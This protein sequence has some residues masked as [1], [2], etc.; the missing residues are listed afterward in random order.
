MRSFRSGVLCLTGE[1]GG[2]IVDSMLSLA[3]ALVWSC[4]LPPSPPLQD[5]TSEDFASRGQK[6]A[7]RGSAVDANN[8]MGQ[9]HRALLLMRAGR[10]AEAARVLS[11]LRQLSERNPQAVVDAYLNGGS[12]HEVRHS[13]AN[14][15][16]VALPSLAEEL[17]LAGALTQNQAGDLAQVVLQQAAGSFP[18]S[19][20][21]HGE[22]GLLLTS[23]SEYDRAAS[24]LRRAVEL[25]PDSFP[26]S[27]ALAEAWLSAKHNFTALKFLL[28]VRGRFESLPKYQYILALAYYDCYRYPEAIAGFETVARLEPQMDRVPFLIGNCYMALGELARAQEFYRK[29]IAMNA[30]EPAYQAAL[31]KMLRMQG[32]ID[33]AIQVLEEELRL[34]PADSQSRYHLALCYEAK[35]NF[36]EAQRLL[37]QVVTQKPGMLAAHVALARVYYHNAHKVKGDEQ[38]KIVSRLRAHP[39][40]R[41]PEPETGP[42]QVAPQD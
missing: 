42:P 15:T 28:S 23:R 17:E 6:E 40:V 14:P 33:D 36:A 37:E 13:G 21:A 30:K 26:Y 11:R 5:S 19:A 24:E 27:L 18:D 2:H 22:Y 39:E 41:S 12:L 10:F 7:P 16:E 34:A 9:Q 38:E 29:A 4:T 35:G 31:G 8:V 1:G 25:D 20:Q 32:H 3:L